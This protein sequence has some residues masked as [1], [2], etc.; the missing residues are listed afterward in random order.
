M[1]LEQELDT[2]P[3]P[4]TIALVEAIRAGKFSD[5]T[6]PNIASVQQISCT[7]IA[8]RS[9]ESSL[10]TISSL[11][12]SIVDK[13][14][15]LKLDIESPNQ[16]LAIADLVQSV[17]EKIHANIQICFE[18]TMLLSLQDIEQYKKSQI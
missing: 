6:K 5:S 17:R 16:S 8:K 13:L 14:I 15:D 10:D 2:E 3:E 11:S 18:A 4:T 7:A 9:P 12:Q 1:I